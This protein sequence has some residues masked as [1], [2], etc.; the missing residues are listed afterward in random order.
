[1][2]VSFKF[3]NKKELKICSKTTRIKSVGICSSKS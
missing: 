2:I 1:L 3:E